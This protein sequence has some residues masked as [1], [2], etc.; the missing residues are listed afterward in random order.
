MPIK[1][2]LKLAVAL[3][4]AVLVAPMSDQR[5]LEEVAKRAVAADEASKPGTKCPL[6]REQVDKI[7]LSLLSICMRYGFGAYD[8]AQRYPNVAGNV[9]AVYGDEE[10]FQEILNQYGHEVIPVIAYFVENRPIDARVGNALGVELNKIWA[11]EMP[12]LSL[13]DATPEQLG[14]IA[15]YEIESRG[16]EMLA[17]FEIVDGVAKRKLVTATVLGAKYFLAGGISDVEKVMVR[18]ERWPTWKEAGSAVIDVTMVLGGASAVTRMA[19]TEELAEK[20]ATRV[21]IEGTFKTIGTVGKT[22]WYVAP[23]ALAYLAITDLKLILALAG[24]IAEL[25]SFDRYVGIFAACFIGILAVMQLFWPLVRCV[26]VLSRW[27]LW[28]LFFL[29]PPAKSRTS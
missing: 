25:L 15:I 26:T 9:F 29:S 23:I 28:L 22:S 20:S 21:F 12:T 8:A 4:L 16:H 1:L 13:N 19:R 18:G 27:V 7:E 14:L 2:I 11:G 5:P 3:V 6:S 24:R 17:E 10:K